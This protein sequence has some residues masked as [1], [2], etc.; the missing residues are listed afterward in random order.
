MKKKIAL[1]WAEAL[2]SGEY[3]QITGELRE[4]DASGQTVGFCCLGVLC[5][6]HAIAHPKIAATQTDPDL[7]LGKSTT[8]PQEVREWAGMDGPDGTFTIGMWVYEDDDKESKVESNVQFS[9]LSTSAAMSLTPR[10]VNSLI[11]L[12]DDLEF[13]F[14]QIADVIRK[15]YKHL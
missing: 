1:Q 11:A 13:N 4:I 8:L 6:L 9:K 5:N 7:Y 10:R 12:N 2:E 3:S 15:N 14:N